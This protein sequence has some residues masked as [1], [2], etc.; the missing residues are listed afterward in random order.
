MTNHWIDIRNSDVILIMG[1]NPASN[2]PIAFKWITAAMEKGAKVICVD[3][4]FTQS[5]AKSHIYAPL[6]SGT[7]IA[8]LGGMIKYILDN[9]LYFEE[10]VRNYTNATFLVN[11]D[12]KLPGDNNGVFSGLTDG[13]YDK[14]TWSYQT[15]GDGRIKKDPTMQDPNCVFQLLK[16]HYSRYTPEVVNQVT[17]TPVDKLIEIYKLYGSTGTKDRS[18]VEL[19]AMGWTQHTVGTQNIRT[20]CMI[21]L[22]L[23]NMGVPGGGVAAMR[24]ESNVQG[25]TD[26]GLLFHI[27]PGYLGTPKA[28]LATLAAYLEKETPS[29]KEPN[30]LNWWKNKPKYVASFLRAMY[31]TNVTLDEAYNLLP[32]IDDGANY[33]WLNLF[34]QM[35]KGKFTGFFAWGMNPACSGAHSNKVRQAMTRL[36][37]LVNVNL[38]DNETGSFWRGPGMDPKKIKT[39]VFLLPCA[40]SIEKEGS[41]IN[42]GRWNQWRYK[43]INPPGVALP[44]GDITS[45]IYFKVK[46]LYEKEGG[47]NADAITKLSWNYG[48]KTFD[49]HFHFDPHAVAKEINGVFLEDKTVENPTKPGE[50]KEFKKGDPVP[51]FA[52]LQDDGSTS[53]GCWVYCGSYT[54]KNMSARREGKKDP[55]G[56]GL[57]PE[58]AWAWPVNR[59]ILYNGAS[60]DPEGNPWSAKKAAIKWSGDKWVGDVPDGAGNPGSGRPPFIMKPDGV[61]SIFGPGLADGPFPE[62]YEP[63]ECPVEKNVLSP[64][65][66]NPTIKRFDK[67]GVGSDLDVYSGVDSCDPKY[68]FICATYRISEHWQTG[69]LTRWCPWLAEMQPEMWCEMSKELAKERGISNGDKVIVSSP[70]GQVECVAIVTP[71]FKP[72]N[73]DGNILH[74]VGIPWHFGWITTK[75]RSYNPGDKKA[76]VFT[77]GDAA[78]L[79]VP[80]IGDANTTIPESKA[81]MVNVVK[82]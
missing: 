16:K 45:E 37:W 72:F 59:R 48:P 28:S 62:H 11:P 78:N 15:E 4:R 74:E 30:S 65:K 73:I 35:Y 13:K 34:D 43:A 44:D 57:Y 9:K 58:W 63:L 24:G 23:G 46:G 79:L 75:D 10:Y 42:S 60:V 18:A 67:P 3:P 8:F 66:N 77:R 5:A 49:G 50:F 82:K 26:H 32:K 81:F 71:R 21:Q 22:L 70:R 12:L 17:G 56:I 51:T 1:S 20:M 25:S 14:S 53:S 52:W 7:D 68:P 36:D 47:P 41:I 76:E 39:E 6:R 54:D 38:F 29:T 61:A 69:V 19:Y 33:S 27:W 31:G 64:Q 55:T 2:H 80:T 40:A